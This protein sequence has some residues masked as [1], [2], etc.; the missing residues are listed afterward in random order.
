MMKVRHLPAAC[1]LISLT[2]LSLFRIIYLA[3][4]ELCSEWRGAWLALACR[5]KDSPGAAQKP[6]KGQ[7]L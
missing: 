5:T 3:M 2:Q 6:C 4:S 7:S 1:G